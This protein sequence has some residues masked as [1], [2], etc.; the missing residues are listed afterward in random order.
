MTDSIQSQI[1]S[2]IPSHSLKKQLDL[3]TVHFSDEDLLTIAYRYAPD[4]ETR[5]ALLQKLE[6]SFSDEL[7][8]YTSRLISVQK[9][10]LESFISQEENEI[11]DLHIKDTPGAYDESYL[12][13]SFDDAVKIIPL[14]YK[15]YD[16]KETVSSRYT[17]VKRRILSE[18]TGF[19]EDNLGELI[20]LPNNRIHSVCMYAYDH[21]AEKCQGE[22]LDCNKPCAECHDVI[23]PLFVKH[24][25]AVKCYET[26]GKETFGI[27]FLYNNLPCG[28]YYVIPLDSNAVH[29]HD[30]ANIHDAHM[31]IPS[32]LVERID[33]DALPKRIKED[34]KACLQYFME[35]AK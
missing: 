14:F 5:I 31:H 10:M 17:I 6:Q 27:V 29:Y 23:F 33:V 2:L 9:Q 28:D 8:E 34:Y 25:D 19:D 20:L 18:K 7:K 15:E 16:C 32:P 12:C 30:Y 13:R 22:C 35:N 26:S 11:Y 3:S 21:Q 4:Y 24:G 1:L